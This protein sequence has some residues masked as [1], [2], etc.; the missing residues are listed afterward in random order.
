[1]HVPMI[2]I[3]TT[4]LLALFI[5]LLLPGVSLAGVAT[6]VTHNKSVLINLQK[7]MERVS[8]ATPS[9]AELVIISPTQLQIN[10]SQIGSTTLI[11]WEKD[12]KPAFF[13]IQVKGDITQLE[14]QIREIA[15]NDNI[16]VNYANDTI[17]LSGNAAN[18]QT[19]NKVVQIARAYASKEES[20]SGSSGQGVIQVLPL[21]GNSANKEFEPKDSETKLKVINH[22]QV[23]DPQQ[24][25]LEVKV[26]QVD[27][28]ALK[29]LGISALIKGS[30]G[31]GFSNMVGAPDGV[32]F[33]RD[34][35]KADP[36][37]IAGDIPWM[38]AISPLSP[39][40][41]G[42]SLYKSGIG[43]VLRALA[44]K[45]LAKMLAEP[46]LLVASGKEGKFL[47]GSRI[48]VSVLSSVGGVA[49]PTIEYI[50]I[51]VKINF[52]PE[53]MENGLIS[54]KIEPA[55][56]SSIAGTL[57]VNGY[58]IIDTREI[59]T[60]VQ[61]KDGESLILGGLLQEETIKTMSKI[62]L[63]GDIPILGALFRSTQD[64]LK[65]KELVFFITPRIV[66]PNTPGNEPELPT[67]K[68]LTPE[69]EKELKWIPLGD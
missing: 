32:T 13:D 48:P 56:V 33:T 68:P 47:A 40:Q 65:E 25:L 43:G 8:I 5:S 24:V 63:L 14:N 54:L 29:S 4:V 20:D 60:N 35:L 62:P 17:V 15:P 27:K 51:G 67:D 49:T 18:E 7:P 1:M 3:K 38:G 28:T 55:E 22:I 21:Y 58:P 6:E 11:V 37:G 36:P 34:G 50:N 16:T 66:K 44:T 26:A 52:R 61:L 12:G 23:D 31:E 42:G 30:S 53:V 45:N 59:R 69:Q 64:D 39:F 9:I 10:G 19:I 57:A 2:N 46:N 41:L